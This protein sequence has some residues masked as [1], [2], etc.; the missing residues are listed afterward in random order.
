MHEMRAIFLEMADGE[1]ISVRRVFQ[2]RTGGKMNITG[3][4]I[5]GLATALCTVLAIGGM[6]LN[7][8]KNRHEREEAEIKRKGAENAQNT[9]DII[10]EANKI[11]NEA[12]TGNHADDLH[13][14]ADQLHNYAHGGK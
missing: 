12:N 13:T 2:R 4:I 8:E 5:A 1:R 11:K 9:A 3:Y 10:T 14:M 7:A 6:A